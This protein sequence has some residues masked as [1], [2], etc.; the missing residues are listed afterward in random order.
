[1]IFYLTP[2]IFGFFFSFFTP[3]IGAKNIKNYTENIFL[4]ITALIFCGGYM[5]GSD[6]RNY[7]LLYND[8]YSTSITNFPIEK[9]FYLL[10]YVFKLLGFNFFHFLVICKLMF[11]TVIVRF[12]K[13]HFKNIY[14]PISIFLSTNALFLLVDNPLRFMIALGI[15]FFSLDY[16]LKRKFVHCSIFIIIASFFH[17]TS[18]F[19]FL[20]YF[21]SYFN[22]AKL[23]KSFLILTYLLLYFIITPSFLFSQIGK[24]NELTVIM[25]IYYNRINFSDYNPFAIGR[26]VYSL[27]FFLTVIYKD[28]IIT[29]FTLGN[30]IYSLLII[31]YFVLL[32]AGNIPTFFRFALFLVP[33]FYLSISV[34]MISKIKFNNIFKY[35]V[36]LYFLLSLSIN[37]YSSYVYLPYSNYFT[38]FIYDGNSYTF[39]ANYNKQKYFERT[40]KWPEYYETIE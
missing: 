25:G 13:K 1:M 27:F 29:Y 23:P 17:I 19:L 16:L 4:I 38:R 2:I 7:E 9:G 37:M 3:T 8:L 6:W 31:F 20:I 35:F 24:Y 5:T 14:L 33:F 26:I 39:R 11:F 15:V 12:I 18:L 21:I 10:M 22:F 36:I 28:K 30:R 40:G 34:L 32:T